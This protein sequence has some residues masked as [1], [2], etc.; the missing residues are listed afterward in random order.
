MQELKEQDVG[1]EIFGIEDFYEDSDYEFENIIMEVRSNCTDTD[2]TNCPQ[3]SSQLLTISGQAIH[4]CDE[5]HA[6][7]ADGNCHQLVEEF[8]IDQAITSLIK[9]ARAC[10][11]CIAGYIFYDYTEDEGDIEEY[12]EYEDVFDIDQRTINF[13]R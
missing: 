1:L 9:Q 8:N 10:I 2:S 5:N 12:T 6:P 4:E 7:D 11:K 13:P 3:T